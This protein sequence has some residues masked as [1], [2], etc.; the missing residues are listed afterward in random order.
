MCKIL[1]VIIEYNLAVVE[2]AI[3]RL[4]HRLHHPTE[5]VYVGFGGHGFS[6]SES[7]AQML[8]ID[9]GLLGRLSYWIFISW[10]SDI[11]GRFIRPYLVIWKRA[12]EP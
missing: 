5:G 3:E 4:D 10:R 1:G 2:D 12:G 11:I 8:A 9:L 6:I 7:L